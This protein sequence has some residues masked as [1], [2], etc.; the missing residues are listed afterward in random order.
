MNDNAWKD[1]IISVFICGVIALTICVCDLSEKN[2]QT[3][4]QVKE[5]EK[6]IALYK[7][8]AE[9]EY[10]VHEQILTGIANGIKEE[11]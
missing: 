1:V 4:Q 10:V 7:E 3:T 6:K 5:L 8:E 2:K 11:W 9:H